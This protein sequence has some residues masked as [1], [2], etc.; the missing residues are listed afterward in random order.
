MS[1]PNRVPAGIPTGGQ[2]AASEK[3]EA[4]LSLSA[5]TAAVATDEAYASDYMA[6]MEANNPA[7]PEP[8]SGYCA[9][10]GGMWIADP[11]GS[12]GVVVHYDEDTGSV[13]YEA[14]AEHVAIP[15]EH[16]EPPL[17]GGPA[18]DW[19]APSVR[20]DVED[21][22]VQEWHTVDSDDRYPGQFSSHVGERG[23]FRLRIDPGD[24]ATYDAPGFSWSATDGLAW[25]FSGTAA[26]RDDAAREAAQAADYVTSGRAE[27]DYYTDEYAGE[28]G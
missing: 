24:N 12:P 4:G 25:T 22:P 8:E 23:G 11:D 16:I 21:G 18:T 10:C 27:H 26:T 1:N 15:E 28:T 9:K 13:D 3:P 17:G 19:T 2:F 7:P 20:V 14:D 5:E 6:F